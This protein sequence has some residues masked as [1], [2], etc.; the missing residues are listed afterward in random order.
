[1][2]E[3]G[4]RSNSHHPSIIHHHRVVMQNAAEGLNN[5]IYKPALVG[6]DLAN[7]L[8]RAMGFSFLTSLFSGSTLAN[9]TFPEGVRLFLLGS[10]IETG[11]RFCNWAFERFKIRKWPAPTFGIVDLGSC[12]P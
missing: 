12:L 8:T 9:T 7:S 10:I 2:I 11:R 3:I 5:Q 6:L 1:M 4:L